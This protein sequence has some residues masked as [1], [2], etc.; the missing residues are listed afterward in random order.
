MLLHAVKRVPRIFSQPRLVRDALAVDTIVASP[1]DHAA[2][3]THLRTVANRL[4]C[5]RHAQSNPT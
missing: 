1:P 2:V 5:F 3:P 4:N